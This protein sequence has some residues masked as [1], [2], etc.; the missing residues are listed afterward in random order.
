MFCNTFDMLVKLGLSEAVQV[1]HKEPNDCKIESISSR[2][3][4]QM[5][6]L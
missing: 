6:L 3:E 4:N 1:V 2:I 5:F